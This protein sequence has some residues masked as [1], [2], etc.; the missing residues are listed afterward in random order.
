MKKFIAITIFCIWHLIP[1]D[2]QIDFYTADSLL[3]NQEYLEAI[4]VLKVLEAGDSTRTDIKIQLAEAYYHTGDLTQSKHYYHQAENT[5]NAHVL[6]R[7]A[8][9]YES[10]QNAPKALKYYLAL[11]EIYPQNTTYLRK[12]AALYFDNNETGEAIQYYQEAIRTQPRDILSIKGLSDIYF[13]TD[14]LSQADSLVQSGLDIDSLHAGLHFLK[15]RIQYRN[16][17]Y[18]G[19]VNTLE[20]MMGRV[21]LPLFYNNLLGY[22]YVQVDSV[23]KAIFHLTLS[24]HAQPHSETSHYFMGW[25]YEKKNDMERAKYYYHK[26]IESGLSKKMP[27]YHQ[28]LARIFTHEHQYS[29]AIEQYEHSLRYEKNALTYMYMGIAA[30]N[31][32]TDKK[33]A[34]RYYQLFLKNLQEPS[35]H[36]DYVKQRIKILNEYEFMK[37]P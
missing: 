19:V 35:E 20:K 27:L 13:L 24:L 28:A 1:A 17:Q 12:I 8:Y 5:D 18:A 15:A 9:I 36:E 37:R 16:N 3:N 23:D 11:S 32:Y 2:A 26:A 22:S 25:A 6:S 33:V 10:E 29:K 30:E 14:S 31:A 7:L 34:V 21:D 4:D